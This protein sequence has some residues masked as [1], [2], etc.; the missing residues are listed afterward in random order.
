MSRYSNQMNIPLPLAVF[1]A[2][3]DYDYDPTAISATALMKPIRQLV[4]T[5]RV[6]PEDNP[7]D[8]AGLVSSRMGS[9]I[10]TAIEN[11]WL[12]G[13]K[14]T[15][16]WKSLVDADE[17][18]P[19]FKQKFKEL[20]AIGLDTLGVPPPTQALRALGYSN[21]LLKRIVVNPSD[22]LLRFMRF[23]GIDPIPVYMEQRAYKQVGKYKVSGKFDFVAEGRVQDFKSTSVYSYLNQTNV[24][25][26][27]LQGSLYRW[28][29]PDIIHKDDMVVN[30]IF[31]DWS[32]AD[33]KQKP[34]YP[35]AR[36]L[37]Q[38]IPLISV[39]E[40]QAYVEAKL[41]QIEKY[42]DAKESEIPY[43]TDEDLWRKATVWKYYK[44]KDKTDGR[45]TKNFDNSAD[46]YARLAD[47]GY[48]GIVIE[49]KG[50]VV[51]CRYCNAFSV[52]T[53]KDN[54]LLSGDLV[55]N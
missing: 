1:L 23:I 7:I 40:T 37:T 19:T 39:E 5:K 52:C 54:Y 41:K 9:A 46:A 47:D 17:D 3:D 24:T 27:S 35:Q 48:T 8:I 33:A 50:Q 14:Q 42:Q 11:A 6:N 22:N 4:L 26:Y 21:A 31:T 53:Q 10:H 16:Y 13:S 30:Y 20:L 15:N 51:A 38:R 45:S 55:L 34:E 2:T 12:K 43:C 49:V 29:N 36:V 28:L 44:H 25:K 18:N 32:A